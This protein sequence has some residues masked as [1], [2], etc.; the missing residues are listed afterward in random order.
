MAYPERQQSCLSYTGSTLGCTPR[1]LSSV[2]SVRAGGELYRCL[3]RET[4]KH[5]SSFHLAPR[6]TA[7]SW[8][9]VVVLVWV[10]SQGQVTSSCTAE[11]SLASS[12]E[13]SCV[14]NQGDI[15]SQQSS[16]PHNSTWRLCP[17]HAAFGTPQPQCIMA[18]RKVHGGVGWGGLRGSILGCVG[19]SWLVVALC[20][21]AMGGALGHGRFAHR[22]LPCSGELGYGG[23]HCGVWGEAPPAEPPAAQ[24][25][26]LPQA[27]PHARPQPKCAAAAVPPV[28]GGWGHNGHTCV[29][30]PLP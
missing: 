9:R 11:L 8:R 27:Q 24:P 26:P 18:H 23:L 19:A 28:A 21:A 22:R 17:S 29:E 5:L 30:V 2:D 25:Q 15:Q 12:N 16:A 1:S 10:D 3:V 20:C 13:Q 14:S 6:C 4:I 7:S